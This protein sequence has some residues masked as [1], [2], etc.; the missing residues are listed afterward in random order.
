MSRMRVR[1]A[2]ACVAA[3]LMVALPSEPAAAEA[4]FDRHFDEAYE[5]YRLPGLAVGIVVDGEVAYARTR[6]ELVAGSGTPIDTASLF[7]IASNTK[8]MT[9]A[10]LAR[11]VEQGRLQ[12]DDPVVKHLPDFRMH[13]DWV[14]RELQVRDLLIHNSGLAGASGDLMF[15]PEP[16]LFTREDVVTALRHFRPAH[17]FRTHY[18]YNNAMYVVAGEVAAAAGGAPFDELMRREVFAPLGLGRCQVGEW[19]LADVGNVAQPHMRQEEANIVIR[20]DGEV[21]PDEPMMAAGGVRC[22]LDD[23]LAWMKAWLQPEGDI[24]G[25]DG[26]VW[27]SQ[28]QREELWQAHIPIPLSRQMREWD[29]SRFSAYGY[30]WRLADV[31]GAWKVSH[32]GTLAGMFSTVVLL[33]DKKVGIVFMANGSAGE[34]RTVLTQALVKHFTAPGQAQHTV[35]Y[36]AGLLEETR[37]ESAQGSGEAP[38]SSSPGSRRPVDAAEMQEMLGRYRDP[39]FGEIELCPAE[40]G[41]RFASLKAPKLTGAVLRSEGRLLVDWRDA[42]VSADAWLDP[43]QHAGQSGLRMD[44]IDRATGTSSRFEDLAFV[45]I[46]DCAGD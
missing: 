14:T 29:G 35:A 42:D 24:V 20:G 7:K 9:V 25:T 6:G 21:V 27:L 34:A 31:D 33:P 30:G 11:L 13:E 18:A 45:R 26:K 36:Y 16:N 2:V 41:V 10:L 28:R 38:A 40:G 15:W 43:A 44:R 1:A 8:A 12:W 5:R 22:G 32:T 4:D 39:W 37:R 3:L 17:S 46:G 19:R 23:M